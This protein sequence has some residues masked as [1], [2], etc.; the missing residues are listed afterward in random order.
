M[1]INNKKYYSKD[2]T[3]TE[4]LQPAF[5]NNNIA[6]ALASDN[7]YAKYLSVAIISLT[8]NM[9]K[10]YN[11]DIVILED[12]IKDKNKWLLLEKVKDFKNVSMRFIDISEY[13][14]K[15]KMLSLKTKHVIL[16]DQP[17]VGSLFLIFLKITIKCYIWT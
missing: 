17:I 14:K 8:D 4:E 15:I 10:D 9:S 11:Y 2:Y 16:Q 1:I 5:D 6:V 7:N 12:K 13:F 3:I